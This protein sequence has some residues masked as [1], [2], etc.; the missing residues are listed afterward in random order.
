MYEKDEIKV[1]I[2]GR[3]SVCDECKE[4]LGCGAWITLIR[5][6]GAL[7]LSC[8]D[9]EHLIFLP[10]GSA[11]LTRRSR[12][13]S[14]MSAIVLKWS[15]AR[16]RY[17]RQGLLVEEEALILAERECLADSEVRSRK[18][19]RAKERRLVIDRQYVKRFAQQIRKLYSHCPA[20]SDIR[21]A[22]HACL[23]YS[24]RVGRSAR[25][26]NFDEEAIKL[27]VIACI[28]HEHTSYVS[29]LAKG[30][31]RWQAREKVKDEV[32]QILDKWK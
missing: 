26:K 19:E 25:A 20:Q 29:L 17:E 24:G 9:L 6:K 22:E 10:S 32:Q 14:K 12:K 7:C 16:R 30:V 27:A 21:I 3:D 23:K 18:K 1:F 5:D 8:A 2:S 13:Y 28:R 11:A 4:D 15:R 31:D